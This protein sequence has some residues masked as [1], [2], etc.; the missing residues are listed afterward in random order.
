MPRLP[1]LGRDL[2]LPGGIAWTVRDADGHTRNVAWTN[3]NRLLEIEG[4]DGVKT[5]TTNAA[6]NCLVASGRRGDVHLIVVILGSS[7]ADGRYADAR[8]LFRWA[9][10]VVGRGQ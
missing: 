2:R 5:G 7:A 10:G 1:L 9:W 3:T 6:G 4:Y 8:N